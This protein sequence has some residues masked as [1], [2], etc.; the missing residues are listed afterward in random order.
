[1]DFS[2]GRNLSARSSLAACG[3]RLIGGGAEGT[4]KLKVTPISALALYG[5]TRPL[6]DDALRYLIRLEYRPFPATPVRVSR[7]LTH[8]AHHAGNLAVVFI[9][10]QIE[11]DLLD[12]LQHLHGV[13]DDTRQRGHGHTH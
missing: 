8:P 6:L 1:M 9:L 10:S 13:H 2:V 5:E 12:I 7:L 11:S 3:T 4:S